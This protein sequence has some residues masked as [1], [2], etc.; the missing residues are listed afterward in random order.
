MI[1]AALSTLSQIEVSISFTTRAQRPGEVSGQ[2]YHFVSPEVFQQKLQHGD[3]LEYAK[4][5][6]HYYG[7]SEA[8]IQASLAQ[9]QDIVLVIDW[10]GARQIRERFSHQQ[11]SV[12]I[13]PP[14]LSTLKE[15]LKARGQ[16]SDTIID[17]RMGLARDEISHFAEYDYLIVNEN[18]TQAVEEL[19]S[20]FLAE[21]L[22]AQ[23]QRAAHQRLIEALVGLR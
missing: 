5:F 17:Y 16:D 19:K 13:L 14:S 4:V 10:Q 15:R 6:E 22:K 8:R 7:T 20:I 9:G 1:Q 18:F 2:H 12:F 23:R 11:T 21:R 3:M